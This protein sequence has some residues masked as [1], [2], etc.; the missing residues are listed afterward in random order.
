MCDWIP[1][2]IHDKGPGLIDFEMIAGLPEI[3]SR[4]WIG[5]TKA[6]RPQHQH[7]QDY[8][9][10]S[11]VAVCWVHIRCVSRVMYF[12]IST[13]NAMN[14]RG[15]D[16]VFTFVIVE[17]LKDESFHC[18]IKTALEERNGFFWHILA[19]ASNDMQCKLCGIDHTLTY[20]RHV[21]SWWAWL[22]MKQNKPNPILKSSE[23]YLRRR[24][25]RF[26][27]IFIY[28]FC[29]DLHFENDIRPKR[30]ILGSDLFATTVHLSNLLCTRASVCNLYHSYL[31]LFLR[32]DCNCQS[33]YPPKNHIP[34]YRL[35]FLR[36]LVI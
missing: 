19:L 34:T 15:V 35:S 18:L 5:N 4:F 6:K 30:F 17:Y 21:M 23:C 29:L 32:Q 20:S 31:M 7:E 24:K 14:Q 16:K 9:Y 27:F 28:I 26:I 11:A 10:C 8:R 13:S 3:L 36:F 1:K 22:D 25:H 2:Q 33:I 12:S